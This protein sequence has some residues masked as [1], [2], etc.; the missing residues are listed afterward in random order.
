MDYQGPSPERAPLADEGW[1]EAQRAIHSHPQAPEWNIEIGDRIDAQ[2]L[3][4]LRNFAQALAAES[5][6]DPQGKP[7]ASILS[8]VQAMR[9]RSRGFERALA[10]IDLP[11]EWES[12]PLLSRHS[13]VAALEEWVPRDSDLSRLIVNPTSGTSGLPFRAP[14]HPRA[15]GAY[16]PLI[17]RALSLHDVSLI[18]GCGGVQAIQLCMQKSTIVYHAGH[19]Y[20][21][22]AAFIKLNL[23]KGSWKS[24][25]NTN[26]FIQSMAPRFISGDPLAFRA[27]LD[28][29]IDLKPMAFLSCAM[30]LEPGLRRALTERYACPVIDFYSSN[31]TGP[32]ASSLPDREG[33]NGESVFLSLPHD[34]YVEITDEA[35]RVLPDGQSGKI[36]LT[37]GRNPYL[38]LLRYDSGD[39]GF[40]VDRGVGPARSQGEALFCLGICREPLLF[41]CPSGAMLNP[42]D[43]ARVLRGFPVLRHRVIQE[44]DLGLKI[45]VDAFHVDSF[46]DTLLAQLRKLGDGDLKISLIQERLPD[47]D[48]DPAYIIEKG[49][50][51]DAD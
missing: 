19:A 10:D 4:Y 33:P 48:K 6:Y 5:A 7:S 14:S 46:R 51:S 38:P 13:L 40:V 29:D 2:D 24:P 32:I 37:G 25:E 8:W 22:G 12:I 16:D 35:G 1:R 26:G 43:I 17:E 11:Q 39:T 49:G 28:M 18:S 34:L 36:V 15:Q 41:R 23:D 44:P 31:E 3:D 42:V 20:F 30:R 50:N 47:W 21:N 9:L 27:F 45:L